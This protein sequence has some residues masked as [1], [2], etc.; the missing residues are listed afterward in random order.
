L[1]QDVRSRWHWL[2]PDYCT[3]LPEAIQK[4]VLAT[5][6]Q[7]FGEVPSARALFFLCFST[8][9]GDSATSPRLQTFLYL[10][11]FCRN[12]S[13]ACLLAFCLLLTNGLVGAQLGLHPR[14]YA[15]A[16]AAAALIGCV[17][18]FYRY[19][20]FFRLYTVEVFRSYPTV[21]GDTAAPRADM[22]SG[23]SK[24]SVRGGVTSSND[25]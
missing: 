17:G 3:P 10:Y 13:A 23:G 8:V 6:R 5:V 12:L 24:E 4:L 7:Q 15:L 21:V 20:K 9:K 1:F 25:K 19:L 14:E 2:F 11:G 16:W 22:E 18:L